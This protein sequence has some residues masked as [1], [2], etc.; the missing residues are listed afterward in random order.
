M[1][2]VITHSFLF[3]AMPLRLFSILTVLVLPLTL[4]CVPDQAWALQSHGPP[5]GIFVHQLAHLFYAA[6]LGYF[7]WDVGRNAFPGKG[8]R[9]LQVFCVLMI[10]WNLDAF[11]G[12]WVGFHIANADIIRPD[13]YFSSQIAG[14]FSPTKLIYFLATLDHL[15]SVPAIFFLFLGMRALYRSTEGEEEK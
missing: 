1:R 3:F 7:F 5:E 9:Y 6:A 8:W 14:P 10:L 12:H 13:G 4:L 15:F 2:P 11:T